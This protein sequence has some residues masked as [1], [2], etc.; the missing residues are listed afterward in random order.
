MSQGRVADAGERAIGRRRTRAL[1]E[2]RALLAPDSLRLN[3]PRGGVANASLLPAFS[4]SPF[5]R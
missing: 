2:H 4:I 1:Q 5:S 3:R